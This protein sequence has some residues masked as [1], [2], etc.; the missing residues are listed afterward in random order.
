M[1]LM[2]WSVPRNA[3]VN[4]LF[5]HHDPGRAIPQCGQRDSSALISFLQFGQR[6]E[7]LWLLGMTQPVQREQNLCLDCLIPLHFSFV[8]GYLLTGGTVTKAGAHIS[9]IRMLFLQL[10]IKKYPNIDCCALHGQAYKAFLKISVNSISVKVTGFPFWLLAFLDFF[11]TVGRSAS[12]NPNSASGGTF[13]A[14][15]RS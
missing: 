10:H 11:T 1:V 6:I 7:L 15:Q 8:K 4:A 13:N 9:K 2:S 5:F 14:T 12:F 3:R